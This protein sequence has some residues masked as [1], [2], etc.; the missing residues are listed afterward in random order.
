MRACMF[1][2]DLSTFHNLPIT[3][4]AFGGSYDVKVSS[5]CLYHSLE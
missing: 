3:V 1:T 4:Y 2:Y 5:V